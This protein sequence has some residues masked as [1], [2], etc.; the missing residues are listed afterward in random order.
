MAYNNK[1]AYT[2]AEQ[3]IALLC[4]AVSHPARLRLMSK[5]YQSAAYGIPF[6][7]LYKDMELH[8]STISQHLK[9]LRDMGLIVSSQRGT[10]SIHR[11]N[12]EMQSIVDLLHVMITACIDN[13]EVITCEQTLKTLSKLD[14]SSQPVVEE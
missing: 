2:T 8:Y 12:P 6:A 13:H 4:S 7:A 10:T 5:I 9:K 1:T 3:N 11:V 14:Y